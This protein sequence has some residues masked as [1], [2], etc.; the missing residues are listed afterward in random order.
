VTEPTLTQLKIIVERAVRPVRASTARKRKMREELLAHVSGVFAEESANRGDDRA[1]LE[2]TAL[3]FGNRAEVTSQLQESVPAS[4]AL[5]RFWEGRA[6][7]SALRA[8][9][10]IAWVTGVL[11]AVIFVVALLAGGGVSTWPPEALILCAHAVLALP[12][13]LLVLAVLTDRMEKALYGPTGR[14]WLKVGLVAAG[15][16]LFFMLW[17]MGLTWRTLLTE[18]DY[19]TA[20]LVLVWLSPMALLFPYALA[21][22]SVVRKRYYDEWASL[23]IEPNA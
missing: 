12:L 5:H 21:E 3:R 11:A 16:W 4:D 18:W 14:S 22:S 17:C 6:D 1:A 7:E 9:L 20:V 8:G 2:R 10:R 15:S 13:Y 19:V 23:P